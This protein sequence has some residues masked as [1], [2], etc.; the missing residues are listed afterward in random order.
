MI[1]TD[2]IF[3]F[4]FLDLD[5]YFFFIL[6]TLTWTLIFYPEI[7]FV[8]ILNFMNV[9]WT[10]EYN[11]YWLVFD[12]LWIFCQNNKMKVIH[13]FAHKIRVFLMLSWKEISIYHTNF[14]KLDKNKIIIQF[15]KNIYVSYYSLKKNLQS[16]YR[17]LS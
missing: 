8:Y 10:P 3:F 5:F 16:L 1:F 9:L 2:L 12:F 4:F 6:K 17:Y 13:Y 11:F 7:Y 14:Q 15:K